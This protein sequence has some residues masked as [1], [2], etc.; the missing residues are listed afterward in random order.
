LPHMLGFCDELYKNNKMIELCY[1][2]SSPLFLKFPSHQRMIEERYEKSL[3]SFFEFIK[4][5]D[6]EKMQR[7]IE[8]VKK[9]S[10]PMRH[11]WSI[12]LRFTYIY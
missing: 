11:Y 10:T 12:A 3:V 9:F 2:L 4:F 1:V 6:S 5:E 7:Y 8:W